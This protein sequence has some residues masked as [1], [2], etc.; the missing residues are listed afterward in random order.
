MKIKENL[1]RP[2][3]LDKILVFILGIWNARNFS[4]W[5][6]PDFFSHLFIISKNPLIIFEIISLLLY[7]LIILAFG[8][9]CLLM[10]IFWTRFRK[11][12]LSL[13]FKI[14]LFGSSVTSL[15]Y[16]FNNIAEISA[17]YVT[18]VDIGPFIIGGYSFPAIY[19]FKIFRSIFFTSVF[20]VLERMVEYY[21]SS[22]A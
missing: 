18:E 13:F 7:D 6:T 15:Y 14:F 12:D 22:N 3:L 8:I 11:L 2:Y 5:F 19:T 9:S 4:T 10:L 21:R 16:A 17:Y 20:I 1:R